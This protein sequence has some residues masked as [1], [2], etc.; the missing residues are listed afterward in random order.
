MS[1]PVGGRARP[2]WERL[3]LRAVGGGF[4]VLGAALAGTALTSTPAGAVPQCGGN[5]AVVMSPYTCTKQR[6]IDGTTFTVLLVVSN[7]V[8][9]AHYSLDAPRATDTPI[10]VRSH[11][12]I[13]SSGTT[14]TDVSGTIPA[15]S[16]SASLSVLLS[17]GQIDVKAVYTA[18]GDSRGRITA[19]YVTDTH[20]CTQTTT[21]PTT[22]PTTSATTTPTT[23]PTTLA[24]SIPGTTP[25]TTAVST[26]A[27][28]TSTVP[29][30]GRPLPVTG[31]GSGLAVAGAVLVAIGLV[32]VST[33]GRRR[34][35]GV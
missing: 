33:A 28:A 21:T 4:V 35:V 18:A 23:T 6:T 24:T 13:S 17:C 11:V 7:D 30:G 9:T 14:P 15:G 34:G 2:W 12:G 22:T 8:V 31:R 29:G 20:N 3:R 16:T 25:P 19:P 32:L 27:A 5:N 10:R 1:S 26:T